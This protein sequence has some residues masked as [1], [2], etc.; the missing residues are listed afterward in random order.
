MERASVVSFLLASGERRHDERK[1]VNRKTSLGR[2]PRAEV[3]ADDD[4]V[5]AG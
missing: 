1:T 2:V 4:L 5:D 3:V